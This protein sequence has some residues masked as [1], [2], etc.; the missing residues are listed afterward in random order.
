MLPPY[1]LFS[2]HLRNLAQRSDP[3]SDWL[4]ELDVDERK[5]RFV[6]WRDSARDQIASVIW[7][8]FSFNSAGSGNPWN[9]IPISDATKIVED[10]LQIMIDEFQTS[11]P[12]IYRDAPT[13]SDP[14]FGKSHLRQFYVED[15]PNQ[16]AAINL[17]DYV[18]GLTDDQFAEARVAVDT[19][20]STRK[21]PGIFWFKHEFMR[22][23]PYQAA[24]ILGYNDFIN[25]GA[26][27]ARHSSLYSGHCLEG[28]IISGAIAEPWLKTPNL[29]NPAQLQALSQFAVDF[30][31]RRVFAGV[32]YPSD[33]VGSWVLTLQLSKYIF[34]DTPQVVSFLRDA[35]LRRSKVFE[36]VEEKYKG[37]DRLNGIYEFLMENI[38]SAEE[39]G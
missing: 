24:L 4:P 29:Y 7:P 15:H 19:A 16:P 30:G 6:S 11:P 32:H 3:M 23:R 10:E 18:D 34:A 1:G 13:V 2:T 20:Y 27:S 8:F 39:V 33:N 37:H 31:D 35:I 38:E 5:R 9:G 25:F 17:R 28:M 26:L 12:Y 22:T 21:L 14:E 36:I